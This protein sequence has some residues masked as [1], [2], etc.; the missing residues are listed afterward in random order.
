MRQANPD[1]TRSEIKKAGQLALVEARAKVGADGKSARITISD[2]EWEAIQAGAITSSKLDRI[3]N[4]TDM[5]RLRELATPRTSRA[6]TQGQTNRIRAM[7][8]SG[9]TNAEIADALHVSSS[10]VTAYLSENK[11]KE[12]S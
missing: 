8:L 2:D 7:K 1:M 4:H 11:R 12:A 9:Y 6:L 3:M 10:T 5:D